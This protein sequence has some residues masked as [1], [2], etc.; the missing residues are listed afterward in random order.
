V[1]GSTTE[2]ALLAERCGQAADIW[3]GISLGIEALP[4][5][6]QG[7]YPALSAH[8]IEVGGPARSGRTPC[9]QYREA[10]D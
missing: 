10:R 1:V 6:R 9:S 2:L 7:L 4:R 8:R 3:L 5:R